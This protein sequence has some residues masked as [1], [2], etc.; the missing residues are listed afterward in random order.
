MTRYSVGIDGYNL[1]L[2]NGTGVA[3]YGMTLASVLADGGHAITG[4]FGID[5]GARADMREVR[6]FERFGHVPT[7]TPAQRGRIRRRIARAALYPFASRRAADVPLTDRVERGALAERLPPFD[8]L[9][10]APDLFAVAYKHF[11]TYGRFLPVTM[12]RPPALMHWTYPVPV[13]LKGARNIYTLHDL[14][15]L[16]LPYT[17]LDAKQAYR[18]M[19]A[20][21]LRHGDHA[22]T[23]SEASRSDIIAEFGV[24]PAHIT[25]CYQAS[26]A[27]LHVATDAR[28]DAAAIQGVFGLPHRGYFLYFGAIEPKKNINRLIE[29]FLSLDS[30]TPLVLVGGRGWQSEQ[31]LALLPRGD[32]EETPRGRAVAER[33]VRLDHLSRA[34]LLKLIRGAKAVVFP[35]V[36]EG[37][38]LPVLEAMQLGTP[39]LTST[40][41][42]L[43]EVAGDAGLLVDP[44]DVA[45]IAA[46]LRRLDGDPA[47]CAQLGR[48]GLVQARGFAPDAYRARLEAMYG[49]VM[50]AAA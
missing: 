29:A 3:T 45:A 5:A 22:C 12:D 34:L 36:Y 48:A 32:E 44:Y 47:L 28:E 17:T 40:A 38:G 1:A 25:N 23:V 19:V 2:P 43:P 49:R 13:T 9:V 16:K 30:T 42:S 18:N 41:S 33:I 4:L 39:V 7:P 24:D 26:P 6:F 14:V 10:T 46:G 50:A 11:R 20:G 35:S 27:G 31:E 8:R 37:F 15:P 21:C